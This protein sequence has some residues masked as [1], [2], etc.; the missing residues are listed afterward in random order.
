MDGLRLFKSSAK[1]LWLILCRVFFQPIIYEPFTVA[2][3]AGNS[4][5][6]SL[7][8]YLNKF[9]EEINNLQEKGFLIH[10]K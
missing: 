9:I 3:Y 8:E 7:N 5:P 6:K 1:E 4:K 2:A 10:N